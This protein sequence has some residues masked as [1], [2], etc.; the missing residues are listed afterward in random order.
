M[1]LDQCGAAGN[2]CAFDAGKRL[3]DRVR[4]TGAARKIFTG[5]PGTVKRW[6]E[7]GTTTTSTRKGTTLAMSRDPVWLTNDDTGAGRLRSAWLSVSNV[8]PIDDIL[9]SSSTELTPI[10]REAAA[11][12]SK[13]ASSLD[14]SGR[15]AILAWLH[16]DPASRAWPLGDPYHAGAAMAEPPPYQYRSFGYQDFQKTL[17]ARP[18]MVYVPANDG[19]IHAFHAGP[20]LEKMQQAGRETP[21]CTTP[22][23]WCAGDE[24]WAYLPVNQIGHTAFEVLGGAQRFF[25]MDLSCR[26]DDVLA[27]DNRASSGTGTDCSKDTADPALC[28]W[29]T[30]LLCGEGWGGSWYTALD[31]SRPLT[32]HPL[33][34]MTYDDGA[35]GFGRTWSLPGIALLQLNG[36]PRWVAV[37]GNGYNTNMVDSN[38]R[39]YLA[40]RYLNFPFA[41]AFAFHGNGSAG[42]VAQVYA[43]DVADGRPLRRFATGGLGSVVADVP[44]V[45]VDRDGFTE[46]A[47]IGGWSG[48]IGRVAFGGENGTKASAA[49]ASWS[50][51]PGLFR[52]QG[53]EPVA[54][55]PAVMLDPVV[56]GR[57]YL[58]AAS[59]RDKGTYPDEA[60]NEP[61]SYD[62]DGWFFTD[63][64]ATAC[65]ACS[66]N[67]GNGNMC[68]TNTGVRMN[69]L[70]NQGEGKR[71]LMGAPILAGQSD[72]ARWLSFTTWDPPT[73]A[74]SQDGEGALYCL[75]F[76]DDPSSCTFCGDL[77][78]DGTGNEADE[79]IVFSDQIPPPPNSADGQIYV[80]NDGVIRV[81]NQDGTGG[82]VAGG[83][84]KPNSQAPRRLMVSWREV[85]PA[86]G[87]TP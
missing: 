72:G 14:A 15:R 41:G 84:P 31:V 67:G 86:A 77:N 56:N 3:Y 80:V 65:A 78:G 87:A 48:D 37:G 39:N 81:A 25:S 21:T 13:L 59:G 63:T 42:D 50:Y 1:N 45:D 71:R 29:R 49:A 11:R 68:K 61:A 27:V 16:G 34:E 47:Y 58:I 55:R 75:E 28:G 82:G 4:T 23:R 85:F 35:N 69:G 6:D 66:A 46:T 18:Y 20:D 38:S 22:E 17:R 40:Y 57:V 70:F 8:D 2:A 51:C 24:A 10:H 44:A 79:S 83:T 5:T 76:S 26:I 73:A 30:V 60:K 62:L 19:M 43:F 32:P 33:W 54:N 36:L 52:F 74:C 64:G 12:L 9:I 7:N 53:V